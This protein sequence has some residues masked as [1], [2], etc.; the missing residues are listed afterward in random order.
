MAFFDHFYNPKVIEQA[1]A[2]INRIG[3]FNEVHIYKLYINALI[4][5]S[6]IKTI[7]M[8]NIR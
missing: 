7:K 8:I 5:T 2:R 4:H 1:E 6:R 3:Q